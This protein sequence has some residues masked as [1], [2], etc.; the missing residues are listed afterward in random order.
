MHNCFCHLKILEMLQFPR[1]LGFCKRGVCKHKFPSRDPSAK[2]KRQQ[3]DKAIWGRVLVIPESSRALLPALSPR[4]GRAPFWA[5][6]RAAS[7][8][9]TQHSAL[10][11]GR[12]KLADRSSWCG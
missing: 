9:H 2:A 1:A 11:P 5:Q 8:R 7:H 4:D 12:G 6:K 10:H 3:Q